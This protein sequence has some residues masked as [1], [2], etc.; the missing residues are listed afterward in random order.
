[1]TRALR[2]APGPRRSSDAKGFS[3]MSSHGSNKRRIRGAIFGGRRGAAAIEFALVLPLLV[4][5]LGGIVDFSRAF[6]E[7]QTMVNA[8][9][10]GARMAI[11]SSDATVTKAS[12]EA[13]VRGFFPD[14]PGSTEVN[15]QCAAGDCSCGDLGCPDALVTVTVIRDFEQLFLGV[16]NLPQFGISPLPENLTYTASG[17]RQ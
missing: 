15:A 4:F 11:V 6:F 16:F 17:R 1:M 7:L 8:A 10:E 3:P 9:S 13:R 5:I 14:N 2:M 12:V